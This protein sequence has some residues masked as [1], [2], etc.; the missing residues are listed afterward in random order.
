WWAV[1]GTPLHRITD[2]RA[3]AIAS[4]DAV[5][6]GDHPPRRLPSSTAVLL[7]M[8]VGSALA[9][10]M[11]GRTMLFDQSM[12]LIAELQLCM[13]VC[14]VLLPIRRMQRWPAALLA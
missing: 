4:V 12:W 13:L 3:M 1:N 5:S 14:L 9:A 10:D 8:A 7:A 2:G 6:L 11:L